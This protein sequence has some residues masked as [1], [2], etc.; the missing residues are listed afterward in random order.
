MTKSDVL[1]KHCVKNKIDSSWYFKIHRGAGRGYFA[2][3][4]NGND[5]LVPRVDL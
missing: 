4:A 2:E 5:P 1:Y 3:R